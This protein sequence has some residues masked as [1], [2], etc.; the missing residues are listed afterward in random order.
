M[1]LAKKFGQSTIVDSYGKELFPLGQYDIYAR[2]DKKHIYV[3]NKSTYKTAIYDY[4]GK[5]LLPYKYKTVS[6]FVEGMAQVST[7]LE[8]KELLGYINEQFE[9]VIPC[10]YTWVNDFVDGFTIVSDNEGYKVIDKS[11][12]TI[13]RVPVP[14]NSNIG[15][16]DRYFT[17]NQQGAAPHIVLSGLLSNKGDLIMAPKY[18][19]IRP[20]KEG[21]AAVELDGKWG[22]ID[23]AG[24][25]VISPRFDQVTDFQ[26]GRSVAGDKQY[27]LFVSVIDKNGKIL[28]S[29]SY[30]SIRGFE[31]LR[32]K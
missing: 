13:K 5:Q 32:T 2:K 7:R 21:L 27:G 14:E 18:E 6:P 9:E 29:A 24:K 12:T 1:F 25:E 28:N 30:R 22:F 23:T 16:L 4:A 19:N 17:L 11:N 20:F 8:G 3:E 15:P 26:N 10:Q 31:Y